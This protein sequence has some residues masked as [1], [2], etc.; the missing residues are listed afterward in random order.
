[1]IFK[2][3]Y[4]FTGKGGV[5]KTALSLAFTKYLQEKGAKAKLAYFK[6]SKLEE[7][8]IQYEEVLKKAHELNIET[9]GLDLLDSAQAYIQK[10][11]GS[12]TIASWVVKTP[13]FKSLI[14]MIPGFNY[15][16]YMGQ[17]LEYL[18]QDPE[19][20][21]ILD[22]PSSGHALTMFEATKNFNQIFQKGAL[23]DDTLEMIQLLRQ[24]NFLQVQLITLPSPLP[25]QES[26]DFIVQLREIEPLLPVQII[27]NNS[28]IKYSDLKLPDEL[29]KKLTNENQALEEME[30]D[31]KQIIP[32]C[33]ANDSKSLVKE[34]LPSMENLV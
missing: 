30:F 11:L 27:C 25:L 19:L 21:I 18:K 29:R 14:N 4:I 1:M 6:T 13:F 10:K 34:L 5:G 9:L 28:L 3:F 15:L 8:T 32:F 33:M 23:Y 7:S 17:I 22:S 12:K 20:V 16:I 24:E 2:R 31:A 26:Q